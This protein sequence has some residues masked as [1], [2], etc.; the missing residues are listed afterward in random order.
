V[1]SAS[2]IMREL[3][4]VQSDTGTTLEV[5]VA[6]KILELIKE[7][8]YF[9]AN[10][11]LC[12]AYQDDDALGRPVVWALK[13]GSSARTLIISG[14][15]DCVETQCY[16]P[17]QEYALNPDSLKNLMKENSTTD[18]QLRRD[19]EDDNWVFGRG[20]ADMKGGLA[21]ALFALRSWPGGEVNVLFTAVSDEENLSAGARQAVGLYADLKNRFGLDY[22]LCVICESCRRNPEKDDPFPF[23]SG[24]PGKIL[25]IVLVKGEL[26][27]SCDVLGGLNSALIMA[28]VIKNVELS[29]DF[30]SVDGDVST[31]PP[32]TQLARDLKEHYDVSLPQYS[33]AAFNM[34]FLTSTDPMDLISR[35]RKVCVR[36]IETVI[37]RYNQVFDTM[38]NRGLLSREKK[39][40]TVPPTM[41]LEELRSS[42]LQKK[43]A[44]KEFEEHLRRRTAQRLSAGQTLQEA[45]VAYL[46]EIV[47]FA[48]ITP[49]AVVIGVAPPYY[50]AVSNDRLGWDS[51][52]F[53]SSIQPN[54][55]RLHGIRMVEASY[56]TAMTDMSYM[57][58]VDPQ[59]AQQV[60]NNMALPSGI[61]DID[62]A[63][64][65]EMNIPTLLIGPAGRDI[66]QAAERV[67]L[68]DVERNVP[69]ILLEI[70]KTL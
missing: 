17:L 57:S 64:I 45:S 52:Q 34:T 29:P 39:A 67:Y 49:P 18:E 66:H 15:Y 46:K 11:D 47:E 44:F 12:G 25:P 6:A 4:A 33:A 48:D 22:R 14:H 20:T 24:G 16:G 70:M 26:A 65:A 61:Y 56:A 38:K 10:P 8:E 51:A 42:V 37:A 43:A 40:W 7:D 68:P 41:T 63:G 27:H 36:S 23:A 31:Q 28:E 5:N 21:A 2:Q 53:L 32:A 13:R 19:L 30:L 9:R 54:L 3:V 55:Q 1:K 35:L 69:E 62:F 50:G 60:M 59:S 58:C